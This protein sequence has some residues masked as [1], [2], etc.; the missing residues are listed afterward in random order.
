MDLTKELKIGKFKVVRR[1]GR[2]GMGA[3]YEAFDTSLHR[4]V[5]IK[6]LLAQ[7][8]AGEES[9]RR[10]EREARAA[11]RLQHQNI[12]TIHELGNFD[13]EEKPYIVMEYLEGS[14]LSSV[15]QEDE[16]IPLAEA[17]DV[18]SQLCRALDFAHQRE[19]IH[20]DVKPSNIRYLD[21]G[22]VKIMDFGIA[23]MAG[24]PQITQ[25]GVLMGTMHYMSPEQVQGQPLD[26]RTDV[27]SAGCILYEMLTRSVPFCGDEPS[28]V[29]YKIVWEEP[30][31]ILDA[32]PD[33]PE[34]V[35]DILARALAKKTADRFAS[36]GEM[37]RELDTVL[38][39]VRKSYP[40]PK[41][42]FQRELASLEEL[43]REGEWSRALPL[44]QKLSAARPD[45]VLPARI[46]RE[47]RRELGRAE[48]D[49]Q[50][51]PEEAS[52]HSAEIADELR[53]F[54]VADG[55]SEATGT[56]IVRDD[57]SAPSKTEKSGRFAAVAIVLLVLIGAALLG[58]TY[59]QSR[60]SSAV[61]TASNNVPTIDILSDSPRGAASSETPNVRPEIPE[62]VIEAPLE[63]EEEEVSSQPAPPEPEEEEPSA[64]A[65]VIEE[66]EA[67]SP[68]PPREPESAPPEEVDAAIE[69]EEVEPASDEPEADDPDVPEA[70]PTESAPPPPPPT[71]EVVAEAPSFGTLVARS[72][73]P[74]SIASVDGPPT[75]PTR[76]PIVSFAPGR[77]EVTLLA[78]DVFLNQK[79]EVVIEEG[80]TTRLYAPELGSASIRAFPERCTLRIDGVASEPPPIADLAIAAGRHVFLFEWPDGTW[81][82]QVIEVKPRQRIYVTG[83]RP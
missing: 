52:R 40:R 44:A 32:R 34:Q 73:Y 53:M 77:H 49:R 67:P 61:S 24:T 76:N 3:V 69:I 60:A 1:L 8:L 15:I 14:D 65:A 42:E 81:D 2:G 6:T 64:P 58:R 54:L 68:A 38:E 79:F 41:R 50:R 16:A 20:R 46:R 59:L 72:Q 47:A 27:F 18:V 30:P 36:A 4:R 66:E 19:V 45:L 25:S 51:S 62:Q 39:V 26:G 17:L 75:T 35:Q 56:P 21:D 22:L 23:R 31:S 70:A 78:P 10:F 12:V 33:V 11:A 57:E 55:S 7:E 82:E 9:R 80:Q 83:Q 43:K 71:P 37:S 74:V 63:R 48:T 29:L 28:A 13:S 5:A